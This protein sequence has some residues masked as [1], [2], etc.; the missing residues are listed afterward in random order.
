MTF[1]LGSKRE[2]VR[3]GSHPTTT[4]VSISDGV[5]EGQVGPSVE[6]QL[7]RLAVDV[8]GLHQWRLALLIVR[9]QYSNQQEIICRSSWPRCNQSKKEGFV[10]QILCVD[11]GWTGVSQQE[12]ENF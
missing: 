11:D 5:S 9:S 6:E 8:H 3:G 10:H 12:L 4:R 7:N 2:V 1:L